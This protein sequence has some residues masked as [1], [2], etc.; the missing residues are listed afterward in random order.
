MFSLLGLC[1]FPPKNVSKTYM[2]SDETDAQ[3][4]K[5]HFALKSCP[6]LFIRWSSGGD[7]GSSVDIQ[8]TNS[9]EEYHG[10]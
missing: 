6:L 10:R 2:I 7:E 4:Y 9:D 3:I 8:V 1:P 5:G